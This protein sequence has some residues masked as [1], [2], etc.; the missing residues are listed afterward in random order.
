MDAIYNK[1]FIGSPRFLSPSK[2]GSFDNS[3]HNIAAGINFQLRIISA[4]VVAFDRTWFGLQ[5]I[6]KEARC[7]LMRLKKQGTIKSDAETLATRL[8]T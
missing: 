4:Q 7:M 2:L 1:D 8:M 5:K 3:V 6:V